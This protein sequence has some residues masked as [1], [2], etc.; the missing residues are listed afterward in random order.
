[1][2]KII[3]SWRDIPAQVVF[4]RGRKRAKALLSARFQSAIDRAAMR[5]RK[6]DT[7]A[8]L[9]EWRQRATRVDQTGDLQSLARAEAQR[10]E[11]A[12]SGERLAQLVRNHGLC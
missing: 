1:M 5:A 12:Y 3:L 10:L 11:A 7:G 4:K 9:N 2:E 8:Y 6:R